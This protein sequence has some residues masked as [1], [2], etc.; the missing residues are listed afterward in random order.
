MLLNYN[1]FLRN[2]TTDGPN[3]I[4]KPFADLVRV[5]LSKLAGTGDLESGLIDQNFW[6]SWPRKFTSARSYAKRKDMVIEC[7][8]A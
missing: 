7:L 2:G 1:L 6:K 8:I 3:L 5:T 4:P